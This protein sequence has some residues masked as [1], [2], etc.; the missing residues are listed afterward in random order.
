[1]DFNLPRPEKTLSLLNDF[2]KTKKIL[3]VFD[4]EEKLVNFL[5]RNSSRHNLK[6][7]IEVVLHN[8]EKNTLFLYDDKNKKKLF[9]FLNRSEIIYNVSESI[10]YKMYFYFSGI[11]EKEELRR[12]LIKYSG[13]TIKNLDFKEFIKKNSSKLFNEY[14]FPKEL[15]GE[16]LILNELADSI[17][18]KPK[19]LKDLEYWQ[20]NILKYIINKDIDKN[21]LDNIYKEILKNYDKEVEIFF[22]KNK[23]V[24]IKNIIIEFKNLNNEN[25][26]LIVVKLEKNDILILAENVILK[27]NK[28]YMKKKEKYF[29]YFEKEKDI[30]QE[31][32][33]DTKN[34][35]NLFLMMENLKYNYSLN[36]IYSIK[37]KL[38]K[39]F[40]KEK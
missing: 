32:K 16:Y 20:E 33:I 11:V 17:Q 24:R 31:F 12:L 6:G 36:K 35:L 2:Q 23:K 22:E 38:K 21:I 7:K 40:F 39:L 13:N 4:E 9:E 28:G 1:M 14:S 5:E 26:R 34:K 37:M 8:F 25:F 18:E 27:T 19:I 3:N 15:N 10:L 29:F 30:P